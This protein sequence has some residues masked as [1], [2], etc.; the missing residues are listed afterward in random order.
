M[1]RTYF[2]MP[3]VTFERPLALGLARFVDA[4]TLSAELDVALSREPTTPSMRMAH[5]DVRIRLDDW[6]PDAALAVTADEDERAERIASEAMAVLRFATRPHISVNVD[7]HRFGLVGEHAI[8]PRDRIVLFD[9]EPPIAAA[10]WK[11]IGG[12]PDFAFDAQLITKVESETSTGWLGSIIG[13]EVATRSESERR[14]LRA[15]TLIDRGFLS[16]DTDQRVLLSAIAVEVL[17]SR[18]DKPK[19]ESQTMAIARRIAYLSC[20]DGCG[21]RE[22]HCIY[23][24]KARGQKALL[25]DLRALAEAGRPWQCS[26]FLHVIAPPDVVGALRY[27]P[28]F[29]ARNTVAHEGGVEWDERTWKHLVGVAEQ[30]VRS[31]VGWLAAQPGRAMADLDAEIDGTTV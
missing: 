11:V 23:T 15:I 14:A 18:S 10:G 21:Q 24:E 22:S 19:T 30:A 3:R 28:L 13:A 20:G 9:R 31:G 25:A 29:T 4:S 8:G 27:P 16:Q 12:W 26:A 2:Q 7:I 17:F 1:N 6:G 5:S